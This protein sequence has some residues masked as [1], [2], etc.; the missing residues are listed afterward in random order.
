MPSIPVSAATNA[1]VRPWCPPIRSKISRVC[2]LSPTRSDAPSVMPPKTAPARRKPADQPNKVVRC[3]RQASPVGPLR[4]AGARAGPG[5]AGRKLMPRSRRAV[6]AYA[7][8]TVP[9]VAARKSSSTHQ[10]SP[11]NARRFSAQPAGEAQVSGEEASSVAVSPAA[12]RTNAAPSTA[13]ARPLAARALSVSCA[14]IAATPAKT[15][16]VPPTARPRASA[17]AAGCP[18]AASPAVMSRASAA[19][20]TSAASRAAVSGARRPTMAAERS[21]WRPVSSSSRVWRTTI[22]RLITPASRAAIPPM[23][24][25]V[26]PPRESL[27]TG[28]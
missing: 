1:S 15:S 14:V 6:R 10:R 5:R 7:A 23:R 4:E 2:S 9:A 28:P 26:R 17:P 19:S 3:R 21:S 18:E 24:Q 8:V 13:P 27:N 20:A 25:A 12:R 22:S 16:P 11:A